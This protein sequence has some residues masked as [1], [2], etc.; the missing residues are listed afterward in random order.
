MGPLVT[1]SFAEPTEVR[2]FPHGRLELFDLHGSAV[3]RF[4]LEPGWH[5]AEDVAP[6]T[7]ASSCQQRHVGYVLTGNL[8]VMMDEGT[9]GVIKAGEM[10]HIEPGHDARTLGRDT[11]TLIDFSDVATYAVDT[12]TLRAAR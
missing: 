8:Q 4:V 12:A 2:E 9:H 1:M 11:V 5:W 10:L 6:L 3:G 7:G